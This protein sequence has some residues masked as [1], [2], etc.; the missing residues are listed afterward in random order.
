MQGRGASP[1]WAVFSHSSQLAT[2][3]PATHSPQPLSFP[4]LLLQWLTVSPTPT[5]A[6][7]LLCHL[8]LLLSRAITF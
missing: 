2:V 5:V 4:C 8:Q 3:S 7:Q 1:S 6:H